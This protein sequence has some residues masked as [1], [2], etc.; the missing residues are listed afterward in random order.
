[1]RQVIA[2]SVITLGAATASA[3]A[4][5]GVFIN[6]TELTGNQVR[7]LYLRYGYAP[8][9][10]HYWYDSRSGAWGI[11]G[12]ETAGFVLPGHDFGPLPEDASRGN[13]GVFINGRELN[14]AEALNIQRT[15]GA[16]YQGRWWLDG[17]TGYW[18]REGNPMPLG[19]VTAALRAQRGGAGSSGDNFWSSR[20]A[21]GNSSGGCGYINLGGGQS[22][23][24]GTCR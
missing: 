5:T 23:G 16:V 22:V 7:A 21:F 8:P 14:L 11:E 13:T 4:G 24:T 19:N 17:S 20:T 6:R 18:G 10:G 1:M 2:L 3:I 15:F 9:A 12:R